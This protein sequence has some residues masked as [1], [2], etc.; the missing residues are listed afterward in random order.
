[1][2]FLIVTIIAVAMWEIIQW[3]YY[4]LEKYQTEQSA[5]NWAFTENHASSLVGT[6]E[7]QAFKNN[8]WNL[9]DH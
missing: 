1:M 5:I 6:R 4:E 2:S 7:G 3:K 8:F 9:F